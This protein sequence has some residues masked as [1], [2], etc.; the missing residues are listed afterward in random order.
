VEEM[1]VL[2][3]DCR[4]LGR[5][6]RSRRVDLWVVRSLPDRACILNQTPSGPNSLVSVSSP[7]SF[8]PSLFIDELF[9][10]Q[11]VV[12]VGCRSSSFFCSSIR[13]RGVGS[14]DLFV[15][16]CKGVRSGGTSLQKLVRTHYNPPTLYIHSHKV[17]NQLTC[18]LML[19]HQAT[20]YEVASN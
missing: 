5:S 7:S 18:L 9:V 12:I 16:Q 1:E 4:S 8:S 20:E 11:V 6:S 14:E 2:A 13:N 3:L 10:V 17:G 15:L 19:K